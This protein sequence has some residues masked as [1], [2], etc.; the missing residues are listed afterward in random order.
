MTIA[1]VKYFL[2]ILKYGGFSAAAD[3]IFISQSSLSKQ[4]K[5]LE[6]ELG[7][8]LF[9]RSGNKVTL[10]PG[11]KLFLKYA[12]SINESCEMLHA[13]LDRYQRYRQTEILAL[14]TLPLMQE[15]HIASQLALFQKH[16]HSAQIN[17]SEADQ[18]DILHLLASQ[19][20][21]LAILRLDYLPQDV[22]EY[23]PIHQDKF[24][25]V[26]SQSQAADLK[27][28]PVSADV[29]SQLPFVML[30]AESDIN[31][32]C[33]DYFSKFQ[34]QPNI[35]LTAGR[36]LYL[37]NLVADELGVTIL[38]QNMVNTKLFSNLTCL[39]L[40]DAMTTTIGVVRLKNRSHTHLSDLLFQHL[41]SGNEI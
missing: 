35:S 5:S 30:N 17:I 18:T 40:L 22:F 26:C 36:H 12:E 16:Y 34:V 24:V 19:K 25:L 27:Q 20:L 9:D 41:S 39:P 10:T 15:Y 37:L 33:Q 8:A 32:L 2:A 14:G 31:K 6:L 21:D 3:E 13:E 38:P 7:I 1:Q 28:T 23:Y 11:G 29:I 4:I